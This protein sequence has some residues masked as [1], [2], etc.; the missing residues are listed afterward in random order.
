MQVRLFFRDEAHLCCRRTGHRPLL[1][2]R[3]RPRADRH[4]AIFLALT[5]FLAILR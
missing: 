2:Q 4:N 5:L 3:K 1:L